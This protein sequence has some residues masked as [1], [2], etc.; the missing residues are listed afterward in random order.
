MFD[1]ITLLKIVYKNNII[2]K[3]MTKKCLKKNVLKKRTLIM[4]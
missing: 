4:I 1:N 3:I 2:F